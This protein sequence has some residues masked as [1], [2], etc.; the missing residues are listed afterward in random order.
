M[1]N[2][3]SPVWNQARGPEAFRK[4]RVVNSLFGAFFLARMVS[5]VESI[6]VY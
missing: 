3:N 1:E 6:A 5:A 2:L 4:G